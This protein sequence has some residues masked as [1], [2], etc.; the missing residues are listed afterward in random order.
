MK[1]SKIPMRGGA[2]LYENDLIEQES[3]LGGCIDNVPLSATT[4]CTSTTLIEKLT[5][6][7]NAWSDR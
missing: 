6:G 4:T 3:W 7:T 1:K 5:D 2:R